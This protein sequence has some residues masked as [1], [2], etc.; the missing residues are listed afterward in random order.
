MSSK[1]FIKTS[2]QIGESL[3][4]E[5]ETAFHL[6]R[7]LRVRVGDDVVLCD[8]KNTDYLCKVSE[9][10]SKSVSLVV[11][12]VMKCE[13]ELPVSVVLVQALP[14]AGK[15]DLI[16]QKAV[17]LGA[18][19]IHPVYTRFCDV[20]PKNE[21]PSRWQKIS[22]SAAGQ[23]GRGIIPEVFEPV[24]FEKFVKNVTFSDCLHLPAYEKNDTA[25][26]LTAFSTYVSRH[27]TLPLRIYV[28]VGPEGGFAEQEINLLVKSG[29]IAVSLGKRILRTETAGLA[30]LAQI[31]LVLEDYRTF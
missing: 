17:E 18:T 2:P 21:K 3:I 6:A 5:D 26:I 20:K 22:E 15:I 11:E 28:Y 29:A 13:T 1:Y 19:E 25:T 31:G 30:A 24:S 12:E 4:L 14:K 23:S 9:V 10:S 16:I 8:G 7:V 27:T